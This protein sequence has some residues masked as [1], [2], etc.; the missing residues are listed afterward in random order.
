MIETTKAVLLARRIFDV[1]E[2]GGWKRVS[3][4]FCVSAIAIFISIGSADAA[5]VWFNG[6]SVGMQDLHVD[7]LWN[8]TLMF[9]LVYVAKH[10]LPHSIRL[11][12]LYMFKGDPQAVAVLFGA[13]ERF[14]EGTDR[15]PRA[16]AAKPAGED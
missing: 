5:H 1:I 16:P 9:G 11:I 10:V 3:G 7:Y 14:E 13:I 8:I 12:A 15:I 4:A 2:K 6:T